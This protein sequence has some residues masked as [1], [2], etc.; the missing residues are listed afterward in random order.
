MIL[1]YAV[2]VVSQKSKRDTIRGR[3][4][5]RVILLVC[6]KWMRNLVLFQ[7]EI[8]I[9]HLPLTQK[10][11]MCNMHWEYETLFPIQRGNSS[12]QS[13]PLNDLP[14]FRGLAEL[15]GTVNDSN[16]ATRTT[17]QRPR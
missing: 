17:R 1:I 14:R 16:T 4:D 5:L 15:L 8:K 6:R 9:Q 13:Q 10:Y 11:S 2:D 3:G 12:K 7:E